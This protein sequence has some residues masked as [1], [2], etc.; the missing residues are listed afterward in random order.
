MFLFIIIISTFRLLFFIFL[1]LD[2][3]Y[4][5]PLE[6]DSKQKAE[7]E[8]RETDDERISSVRALREWAV[9]RKD[10]LKTPLGKKVKSDMRYGSKMRTYLRR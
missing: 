10:W 2:V 4:K 6:A 3:E 5:F 8:L 7:K 9:Q 1:C